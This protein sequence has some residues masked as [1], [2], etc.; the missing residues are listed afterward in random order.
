MAEQELDRDRVSREAD[1]QRTQDREA[2]EEVQKGHILHLW[3]F[4]WKNIV[5]YSAVVAY[6]TAAKCIKSFSQ[7]VLLLTS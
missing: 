7:S 6:F 5:Y 4:V 3:G 1:E 2:L